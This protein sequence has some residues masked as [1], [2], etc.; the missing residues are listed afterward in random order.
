MLI[1]YHKKSAL[2]IE[3]YFK[4]SVYIICA[5]DYDFYVQICHTKDDIIKTK[6]KL[7]INYGNFL[8]L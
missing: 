6:K 4:N 5:L 2:S 8:Q 7:I 1:F 3:I